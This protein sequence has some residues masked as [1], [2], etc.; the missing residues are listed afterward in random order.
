MK[1]PNGAGSVYK[2]SGKR[3]KPWNV[4]ITIG[5]DE[6]GKQLRKSCGTFATKKEALVKLSDYIINSDI[7]KQSKTL[8]NVIKERSSVKKVGEK[9]AYFYS[10]CSDKMI[11]ELKDK[12]ISKYTFNELQNYI[13]KIKAT[14][15]V[16]DR[17]VAIFEYAFQQKYISKNIA[18]GLK[19]YV[20]KKR[21]VERHEFTDKEIEKTFDYIIEHKGD[22]GRDELI[23]KGAISTIILIYT[24]LRVDE[25]VSLKTK[26]VNLDNGF[27]KVSKSKTKNGLRIIPIKEKIKPLLLMLHKNPNSEYYISDDST[28]EQQVTTASIRLRMKRF[29][30]KYLDVEHNPHD[31]RHTFASKLDR[32]GVS[33]FM[34]QKLLGHSNPNVTQTYV[35]KTLDE[36]QNTIINIK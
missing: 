21:S 8:S 13:N 24:G 36:L 11:K 28:S 31:A 14:K 20:D 35:H 32:I 4:V 16:T 17:I 33:S 15:M 18:L 12:D 26:D 22:V 30:K 5:Y 19:P 10:L 34:M 25:F 6:N 3:R 23:L 27:L 29:S 7:Y 1:N 2:L 9:T